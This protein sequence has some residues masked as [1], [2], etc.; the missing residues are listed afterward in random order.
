MLRCLG[1]ILVV[2]A[3]GG[4]GLMKGLQYSKQ[5]RLLR[6]F[7]AA[8]EILNC[9]LNYTMLPLAKLYQ[10]TSNRVNGAC[11]QFFATLSK[12]IE[13]GTPRARA[14]QTA[15]HETRGLQLP[16][17]ATM[18]VLELCGSLG[19]LDMDG[20]N[21]MLRLTGQRLKSALERTEAEKKPLAKSYASLG[22]CT[23]LAL[24][25]LML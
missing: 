15:F 1:A 7:I 18:A 6:E 3:A 2:G 10:V 24:M 4:F 8:V 12:E 25:I 9:E 20:E 14:A 21:R 11:R 22:F 23:G 16:N 17:D 5:V 19:R 13:R